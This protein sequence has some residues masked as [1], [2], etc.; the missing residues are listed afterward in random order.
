MDPG[1]ELWGSPDGFAVHKELEAGAE[2]RKE[3]VAGIP[4]GEAPVPSQKLVYISDYHAFGAG[5]INTQT[6]K[7]ITLRTLCWL[8]DYVFYLQES[9]SK[10]GD[11][12]AGFIIFASSWEE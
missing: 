5:I 10:E 1:S 4:D 9:F 8:W 11:M 3:P 12:S 6:Y 2:V 7:F